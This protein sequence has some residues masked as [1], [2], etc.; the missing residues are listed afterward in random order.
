MKIIC[1]IGI[2]RYGEMSY[3]Y[4]KLHYGD[5]IGMRAKATCIYCDHILY[6]RLNLLM[7]KKDA[8]NDS[9]YL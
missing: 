9:L 6:T 2:H 3:Q 4:S 7:P 5:A 1:K 8:Y